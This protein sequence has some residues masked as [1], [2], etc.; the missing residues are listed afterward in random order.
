MKSSGRCPLVNSYHPKHPR[1]AEVAEPL[2]TF[3]R[4]SVVR[5]VPYTM[6]LR[7]W[8]RQ[9]KALLYGHSTEVQEQAGAKRQGV[10]GLMT[11]IVED[12]ALKLLALTC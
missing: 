4:V 1:K 6:K 2:V 12:R 11:M 9:H 7:Q 5:L 10:L 3:E 8:M